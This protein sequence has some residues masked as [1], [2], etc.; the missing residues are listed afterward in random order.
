MLYD[1]LPL[2]DHAIEIERYFRGQLLADGDAPYA[3]RTAVVCFTNRCGSTL[4]CSALSQIGIAGEPDQFKNYEFLNAQS[5][6]EKSRRLQFT[7]FE[8]Y[9]RAC[10]VEHAGSEGWFTVKSSIRQL[11]HLVESGLLQRMTP[12]PV[13][14]WVRRRNVLAQAV[15]YW[16][17]HQDGAWTSLHPPQSGVAPRY[18]EVAITRVARDIYTDNALF[19]MFF[20]LHGVEPLQ[21][22]YEDVAQ[23]H[24][25]LISQLA[26]AF[27][28]SN[29]RP[30]A[31]RLPVARQTSLEKATWEQGVR[32]SVTRVVQP[33]AA[34]AT[35]SPG[36]RLLPGAPSRTGRLPNVGTRVSLYDRL[37][38][39]PGAWLS[40]S[41]RRDARRRNRTNRAG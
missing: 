6:V 7:S 14:I 19:E 21:L 39:A 17:A 32:R 23:N 10:A 28:V 15:S 37:L 25:A 11:N 35:E 31:S 3:P 20:D 30:S 4:V 40:G 41:S 12:A 5:V 26:E 34:T 1:V 13:V 2:D 16:T 36:Q 29:I 24:Q 9:L 33:A 18:D 8:E 22:W 38:G 27:G